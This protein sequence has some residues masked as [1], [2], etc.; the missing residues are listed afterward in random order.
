MNILLPFSIC[1]SSFYTGGSTG[2]KKVAAPRGKIS[3][4]ST[5]SSVRKP[6]NPFLVGN[7][8]KGSL[9]NLTTPEP[10][11]PISPAPN[12]ATPTKPVQTFF[13]QKPTPPKQGF[14]HIDDSD[15]K[16]NHV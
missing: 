15:L 2:F 1:I 8:R 9:P 6:T 16:S 3:S 10:Y 13:S 14:V 7:V 12:S 5:T 4:I 11:A